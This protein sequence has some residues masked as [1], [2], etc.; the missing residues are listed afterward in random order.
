MAGALM[1]LF[2]TVLLNGCDDDN[3]TGPS[4]GELK[5]YVFYFTGYDGNDAGSE[6]TYYRYY[7][8]QQKVD[9]V[10]SLGDRFGYGL[11]AVSADGER[12]YFNHEGAIHVVNSSTFETITVLDYSGDVVVS[13]DNQLIAVIGYDIWILSVPDYSVV[14]HD[15]ADAR[16]RGSAFS[17]NSQRFYCG[18][19]TSG[20]SVYVVD[21]EAE[22]PQLEERPLPYP[23]LQLQKIIPSVDETKWFLYR[24]IRHD[25][26]AFEVYDV[27][28]DSLV[29]SLVFAPGYGD[30]AMTPDGRYVFITNPGELNSDIPRD[31]WI[32]VFDVAANAFASDIPVI[33]T[34]DQL[35]APDQLALSPDGLRLVAAAMQ[36]HGSRFSVVGV[37]SR[38]QIETYYL[39]QVGNNTVFLYDVYCQNGNEN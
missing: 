11:R 6:P 27:G 20:P 33:G 34:G 29:F 3:P 25:L 7:S 30:M 2:G 12:L 15:T 26:F 19:G 9:T 5:D 32:Y 21:L 17:T 36:G 8:A 16:A 35:F 14:F 22:E 39:G 38:E 28:M 4:D 31:P 37:S 13:P 24:R 1:L 23:E 18:S 10:G